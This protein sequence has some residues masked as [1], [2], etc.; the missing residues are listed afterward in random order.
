MLGMKFVVRLAALAL[1]L[2]ACGE[3]PEKRTDLRTPDAETGHGVNIFPLVN[4]TPTPTAS[5][6]A[7]PK[8]QGGPVT[9]EE[10]RI[11]RG[12]S[13]E[14]RAGHVNAASRYFTV[15]SVVSNAGTEA[16]L[17][18]PADVKEFNKTL[19]CGAKLVKTRR[20]A[21]HFVVGTFELTERPG[22]DCGTGTGHLAEVA[23]LIQRH[24]ITRWVR[25]PDPQPD[26]KAAPSPPPADED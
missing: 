15:P 25:G 5:P 1:L 2:A 10:K 4:P 21:E 16:M 7:T 8:P 23:F 6:A 13:Q 26:P 20:S 18:S 14:L 3:T 12:W 9:R 19:P 17:S 22:A 24:R 11:I